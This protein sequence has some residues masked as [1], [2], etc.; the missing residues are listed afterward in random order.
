VKWHNGKLWIAA[1]APGRHPARRS[2]DVGSEVLIRVS[3]RRSLDSRRGVRQRGQYLGRDRQQQHQLRRGKAGLNKYD[4]KTGQLLMTVDFAARLVRPARAGVAR[5]T[6]HQLRCRHPPG[7]EGHGESAHRLH[8]QHRYRLAIGG[9]SSVIVWYARV[10][11]SWPASV[12][13]SR[14]AV[15]RT[16]DATP[17]TRDRR[18][19]PVDTARSGAQSCL[20]QD[21]RDHRQVIRGHRREA[22]GHD[23]DRGELDGAVEVD[24]SRCSTGSSPETSPC[25]PT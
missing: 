23:A 25:G 20:Q 21:V 1:P 13:P 8:L 16:Q 4:G 15:S 24:V 11:G 9:H 10:G 17:P 19:H 14:R 3:S 7:M 18:T 2:D 22:V 6:P 5:R 12:R